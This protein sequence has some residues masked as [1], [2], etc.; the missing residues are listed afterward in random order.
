MNKIE[1]LK[2]NVVNK[3]CEIDLESLT[4]AEMNY[5]IDAVKKADE[6]FKPDWTEKLLTTMNGFNGFNCNGGES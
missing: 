4:M 6:L 1:R 2:K 3:L 5:Y